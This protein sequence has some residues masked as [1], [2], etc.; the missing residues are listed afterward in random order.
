L[1]ICADRPMAAGE[2]SLPSKPPHPTVCSP[3]IL[4]K[5]SHFTTVHTLC[6]VFWIW[7]C[8]FRPGTW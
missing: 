8:G 5:K 1:G 3:R 7:Y 2:N 6:K 4:E